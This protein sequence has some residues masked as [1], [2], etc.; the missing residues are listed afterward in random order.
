M[1]TRQ[2]GLAEVARIAVRLEAETGCPAQMLIAQWALESRWGEKPAG[3][4]NYF[5][6]KRSSRH[7]KW[8]TVSTREVINGHEIFKELDFA[9]YDSLEESCRDYVWLLTNG[10]PYRTAWQKYQ[11]DKDVNGLIAA[12]AYTYATDPAYTKLVTA[13]ANQVN[14]TQAIAAAR[15]E[16]PVHA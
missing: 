7:Q 12:I 5:G 10:A 2:Q 6:I 9:D 11:A 8:C 16:V 13:I 15:Q 4:A 14:V 1:E 3:H